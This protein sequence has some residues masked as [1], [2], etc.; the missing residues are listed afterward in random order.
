MGAV[1]RARD[2]ETDREVALKV[3]SPELVVKPLVVER[4]R[5]E[6]KLGQELRHENLVSIYEFGE[7]A[8]TYYLAL[9]FVDGIDLEEYIQR[10]GQLGAAEAR[11]I[12]IQGVRALEYVHQHGVIHRD[13]K[14]S[15]FL[16]ASPGGK[17]LVKL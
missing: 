17:A 6:A 12:L 2:Q 13:V 16:I 5:R 4:F 9:E 1:Y 14:P 10:A 7:S 11:H 15:N 8:G 3:L